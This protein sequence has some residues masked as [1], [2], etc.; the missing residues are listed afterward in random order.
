MC[1]R[2]K[3][4]VPASKRTRAAVTNRSRLHQK[5]DE[6]SAGSRR[7]R[8]LIQAF[9][10]NLGELSEIDMILVRSAAALTLKSEQLQAAMASGEAVDPDTLIRLSGEA[11]RSL[12]A[13]SAK[14]SSDKP[15]GNDLQTYLANRQAE[16]EQSDDESDDE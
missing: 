3:P 6:R 4:V 5:T 2:R 8:D 12:A 1:T 7:F 11:R 14:A 15:A 9:S 13:I 10:A 16:A